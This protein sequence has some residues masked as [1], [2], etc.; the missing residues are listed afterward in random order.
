MAAD[1][2]VTGGYT[3]LPHGIVSGTGVAAIPRVWSAV[4]SFARRLGFDSRDGRVL[5][6]SNLGGGLWVGHVY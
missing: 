3:L 5:L 1:G 2:G 4:A 6:G